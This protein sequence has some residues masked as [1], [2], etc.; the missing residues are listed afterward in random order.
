[1]EMIPFALD[2]PPA[3]ANDLRRLARL[4]SEGTADM[5][6]AVLLR[7][8]A[9]GLPRGSDASLPPLPETGYAAA[10]RPVLRRPARLKALPAS[11][12]AE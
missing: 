10:Q 9:A 5:I 1:M 4:R 11:F 6:R 12:A 7:E 8:V 3:L 2:L